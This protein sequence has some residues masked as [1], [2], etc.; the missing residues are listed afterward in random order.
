MENKD[1][2]PG[3]KVLIIN[4]EGKLT[5]IIDFP[6]VI[7]KLVISDDRIYALDTEDELHLFKLNPNEP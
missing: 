3:K 5:G 4:E 6:L 1:V 7:K 2:G